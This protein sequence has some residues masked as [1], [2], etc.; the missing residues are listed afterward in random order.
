[1]ILV[2]ALNSGVAVGGAGV[3]TANAHSPTRIYGK[4]MGVYVKYNDSP[5]ATTDITIKTLGTAPYAPTYNLLVLTDANTS[6]W[7]YPR[8]QVH[9]TAGAAIAG[10]YTPLM[11]ADY[12]NIVIAQANAGDSVDVWLLIDPCS[13]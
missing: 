7:F 2:G 8:A 12:L 10:E 4:V 9:T 11:V 13:E 5:P 6:G 1:M 3:A